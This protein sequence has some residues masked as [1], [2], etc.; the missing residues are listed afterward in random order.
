MKKSTLWALKTNAPMG[1]R[2]A[3]KAKKMLWDNFS[4][5]ATI[6]KLGTYPKEELKP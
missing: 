3:Q 1:F 4:V 6:E 2:Q 5:L